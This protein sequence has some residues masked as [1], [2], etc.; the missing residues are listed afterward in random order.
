M[1]SMRTGN[2]PPRI[3]GSALALIMT[4]LKDLVV[5]PRD[6]ALLGDEQRALVLLL[7]GWIQDFSVLRTICTAGPDPVVVTFRGDEAV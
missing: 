5:R 1:A 6:A 7:Y 2:D 4:Q 3:P